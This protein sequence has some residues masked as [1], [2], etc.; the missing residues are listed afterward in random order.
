MRVSWLTGWPSAVM[1]IQEVSVA[2]IVR[3]RLAADFSNEF[4]F[5]LGKVRTVTSLLSFWFAAF[6]FGSCPGSAVSV[7][8]FPAG[9]GGTERGF[10]CEF[11]GCELGGL[12]S[13]DAAA[14]FVAE[15]G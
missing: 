5:D 14:M 9:A 13:A 11:G 12:A 10:G 7:P 8:A 3:V 4:E 1:E 2:R 6:W 15:D